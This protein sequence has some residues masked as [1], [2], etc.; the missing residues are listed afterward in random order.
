MNAKLNWKG[1]AELM[2]DFGI[3]Y[4]VSRDKIADIPLPCLLIIVSRILEILPAFAPRDTIT[5]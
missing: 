4:I 2:K 5:F 3:N 1:I